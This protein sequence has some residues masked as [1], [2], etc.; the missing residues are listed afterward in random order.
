MVVF[1][2]T[3][4]DLARTRFAIS[5]TWELVASLRM[6]RDPDRAVMHLPWVREALPAARG[7][8]L[9]LAFALTPTRGYIPDF[10]TPPPRTPVAV[11]D[12]ELEQVRATPA[13]QVRH[14][15]AELFD[16]RPPPRVVAAL[17]QEPERG[18]ARLVDALRS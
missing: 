5:P 16:D 2:F 14:D 10:L 6:L 8:D 15:V 9:R 7:L 1:E 12:E 3:L 11:V 17:V 4:D 13:D 18:L